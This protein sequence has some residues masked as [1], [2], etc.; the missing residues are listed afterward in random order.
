MTG[1]AQSES[2]RLTF[3]IDHHNSSTEFTSMDAQKLYQF[4][5]YNTQIQN[6][7]DLKQTEL[8]SSTYDTQKDEYT[9]VD[10][11]QELAQMGF[12]VSNLNCDGQ[13]VVLSI[14]KMIK[15]GRTTET[16]VKQDDD[17][18]DCGDQ[19]LSRNL[20]NKFE[21]MDYGGNQIN[22][23]MMED[24]VPTVLPPSAADCNGCDNIQPVMD[25]LSEPYELI[26]TENSIIN[27]GNTAAPQVPSSNTPNN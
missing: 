4:F 2:T 25:T 3:E 7:N 23:D 12:A 24:E 22:F 27:F 20:V 8:I 14:A 21:N 11:V 13:T 10:I 26:D 19:N 18:S 6:C 5:S 17:C 16:I 1:F 15:V 9:S